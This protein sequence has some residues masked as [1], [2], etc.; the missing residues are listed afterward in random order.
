MIS[1]RHGWYAFGVAA[2]LACSGSDAPAV[3]RGPGAP[4]AIIGPAF[5]ASG[6]VYVPGTSGVLFVDDDRTREVFWMELTSTGDQMGRPV[7]VSLGA[8]VTDIEGI[9]RSGRHF[10][11][12]GSQS[13]PTGFDGDGLVRFTF[14]PSRRLAENVE[15]IQGMKAWLAANVPE[16][17]G[18]A[19]RSGDD[20]LNIEAIAWD[21]KGGRLLLGLRAPVVGGNALVIPIRLENPD[22][23]FSAANLRVEG[24][25]I[26]LPLQGAGIRSL[27]YDDRAGAFRL[28]TG[29]P[30][31]AET[32]DFRILEWNG[33]SS[34]PFGFREIARY[35][36]RWKP[37]GIA[38]ASLGGRSVTVVVFDTGLF[39][40]LD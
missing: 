28:I 5:E 18:A 23:P 11:V 38:R 1:L 26:A 36:A 13:K 39:A 9:T 33:A 6:V 22:G 4:R 29:A 21:P 12:V 30:L 19:H 14:D 16:L 3:Q 10:Y 34:A 37:E 27:E 32:H 2:C 31:N 35:A 20:V 15:R 7:P 25:A 40:L 24:R 8:D 17:R